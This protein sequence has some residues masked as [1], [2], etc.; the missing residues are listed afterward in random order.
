[1]I[2]KTEAFKMVTFQIG[3]YIT[4]NTPYGRQTGMVNDLWQDEDGQLVVEIETQNQ[5]FF[6]DVV[7]NNYFIAE[8]ALVRAIDGIT[9]DEAISL[10][11]EE[12]WV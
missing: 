6:S 12:G 8:V 1:M 7:P 5:E 2:T 9:L 10:A 4:I 3:S 11:H